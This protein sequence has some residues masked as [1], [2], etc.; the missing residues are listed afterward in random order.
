MKI[1]T[2]KLLLAA[3][4][5]AALLLSGAVVAGAWLGHDSYQIST[6]AACWDAQLTAAVSFYYWKAKNEN[7]SKYAMDLVRQFADAY[8]IDSAIALANTILRD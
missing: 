6:V 4:F 2:S 5:T 7:R 1:E 8:G 3:D